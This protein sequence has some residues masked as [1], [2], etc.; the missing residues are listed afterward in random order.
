MSQ[1]GTFQLTETGV[2]LIVKFRHG[3]QLVGCRVTFTW[4]SLDKMADRKREM[5]QV[6]AKVVSR[7]IA[8]LEDSTQDLPEP[9]VKNG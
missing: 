7:T 3:G 9:E 5:N 8:A 1:L 4:E 6:I 2:E